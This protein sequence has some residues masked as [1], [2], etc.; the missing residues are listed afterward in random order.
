MYYIVFAVSAVVM[1]SILSNPTSIIM[2]YMVIP[3]PAA[4]FGV[5][6]IGNEVKGLYSGGTGTANVAHLGSI[7]GGNWTR[8]C[9]LFCY[10]HFLL[11]TSYCECVHVHLHTL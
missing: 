10:V 9:S 8:L 2:L 4:L 7:A 1:W 3:V 5:L 11:E 6:Y